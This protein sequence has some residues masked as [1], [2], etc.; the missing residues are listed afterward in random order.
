MI[1]VMRVTLAKRSAAIL[2]LMLV[3]VMTGGAERARGPTTRPTTGPGSAGELAERARVSFI[4][5]TVEARASAES[6]WHAAEAGEELG[7]A[8]QVR[9]G[10]R[11]DV[12][13]HFANADKTVVIDRLGITK[14][15]EV[16]RSIDRAKKR[17][18]NSTS[19]P[20]PYGRTRYDIPEGEV[21][22]QSE[23]IAESS[24][25]A[26]RGDKVSVAADRNMATS[27]SATAPSSRPVLG[28]TSS[29]PSTTNPS[30]SPND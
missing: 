24:T 18:I 4:K 9:L 15:D 22:H 10:V 20:M 19:R 25:L 30:N 23:I 27:K 11:S 2:F 5:G 26:I 29:V 21:E 17:E 16:F 1:S 3:C 28:P 7:R 13:I 8:A 14:M 6:P 12:F